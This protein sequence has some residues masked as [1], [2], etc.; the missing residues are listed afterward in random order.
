M[1][2]KPIEKWNRT[3]LLIFAEKYMEPRNKSFREMTSRDLKAEVKTFV[4]TADPSTLVDKSAQ[5]SVDDVISLATSLHDLMHSVMATTNLSTRNAVERNSRRFLTHLHKVCRNQGIDDCYMRIWNTQSLLNLGSIIERFGSLKLLW[6][7]G[8]NG[9]GVIQLFKKEKSCLTTNTAMRVILNNVL[10]RRSLDLM[11]SEYDDVMC[12]TSR[13]IYHR[14]T[15]TFKVKLQIAK[16]LPLSVVWLKGQNIHCCVIGTLTEVHMY[17]IQ[18]IKKQQDDIG[19]WFDV[20][21][22]DDDNEDD[23]MVRWNKDFINDCKDLIIPQILLPSVH[24]SEHKYYSIVSMDWDWDWDWE[25]DTAYHECQP[26]ANKRPK[27]STS[28]EF[29]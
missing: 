14:Y 13:K 21:L 20:S 10:R 24:T 8:I 26:P 18:C 22:M 12:T 19:V 9:E 29:K 28:N 6:E 5:C 4:A 11:I 7:G 23:P 17:R 1:M 16:H 15:S 3:K 25:K 2:K 27:L